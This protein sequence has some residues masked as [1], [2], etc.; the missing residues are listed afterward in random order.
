MQVCRPQLVELLGAVAV[1]VITDSGDVVGQR[2]QPYVGNVLRIKVYRDSPAEGGSGYTEILQSR[3]EEVVHHLVL[4]GNRLDELGWVLIYSIRLGAY[5]LIL[6]KYASSFAG[7]TGRP[8][9]GHFPSTAG[10]R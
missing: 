7:V 4:S 10:T 8:Q 3:K 2:I 5:L 1:A 6:K 9:S